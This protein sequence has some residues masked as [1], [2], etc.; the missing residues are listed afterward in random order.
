MLRWLCVASLV[1]TTTAIK[2]EGI[3]AATPVEPAAL[4]PSLRAPH[5]PHP[6]A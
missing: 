6:L 3:R 1:A 4:E 2:V 5:G